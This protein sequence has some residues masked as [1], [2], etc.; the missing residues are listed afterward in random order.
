MKDQGGLILLTL[1]ADLEALHTRLSGVAITCL[2]YSKFIDRVD[3]KRTFFYLDPP[4][5]GCENDYGKGMFDRSDFAKL[6]KQL[7]RIKG[8]FLLSINDRP[9]IREMFAWAEIKATKVSYSIGQ[10]KGKKFGE[11]LISNWTYEEEP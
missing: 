2:D 5:W 7:K 8:T 11:L 4:Y 6:S 9:E 10:A 3:R 1:E